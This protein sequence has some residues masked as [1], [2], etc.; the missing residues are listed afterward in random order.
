MEHPH[1]YHPYVDQ[2]KK[3][4]TLITRDFA[5]EE[6]ER[7]KRRKHIDHR[8]KAFE[9]LVN[10]NTHF[11]DSTPKM[12]HSIGS[13]VRCLRSQNEWTQRELALKMSVKVDLIRDIEN[14]TA[15]M[16]NRVIRKLET[17][18]GESIRD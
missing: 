12:G 10:D 9:E 17:I 7:Q 8:A 6:A 11:G 16:D 15:R 1:K 4:A 2:F 5:A 3:P 13:R 18:F 14:G